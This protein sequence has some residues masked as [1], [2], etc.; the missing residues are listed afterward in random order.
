[1]A[2]STS[3]L[4]SLPLEL[5]VEILHYLPPESRCCFE[6]AQPTL[7]GLLPI[8]DLP[9]YK[10]AMQGL[11]DLPLD[12]L[13]DICDYLPPDALL[14]LRLT[15]RD[16]YY[17]VPS[18]PRLK[19]A[20]LSKCSRTAIR[21]YLANPAENTSHTRCIL[22]KAVYPKS[23]FSSNSSPACIPNPHSDS[24]ERLEVVELPD[25]F[26]A[27]HVGRLARVVHTKGDGRNEWTTRLR[28]MCMHC[29]SI[30][31]WSDCTCTCDSCGIRE[32]RTYT[33]YLNNSTE[34][35][36]FMFWRNMGAEEGL[37]TDGIPG[38]LWV[39]EYCSD[40]GTFIGAEV[41]E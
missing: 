6:I 10:T 19:L 14:A 4:L 12:L 23:I 17:A 5:L 15:Q 39:R 34:C 36:R 13:Y 40:P 16:L 28:Q 8:P 1:M 41:A 27:W 32:V 25:R 11:L 3:T 35:R 26:C 37:L 31:G 20:T 7:K 9:A 18:P 2:P 38:R 21:T 22:C 29:G 33:R 24:G 30:K